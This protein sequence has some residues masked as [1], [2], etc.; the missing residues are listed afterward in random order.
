MS[1]TIRIPKKRDGGDMAKNGKVKTHAF[2]SSQRDR[3]EHER[4]SFP[5]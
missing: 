3:Q 1:I 5:L 4:V 2:L